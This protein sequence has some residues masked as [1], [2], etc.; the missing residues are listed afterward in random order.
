MY[1]IEKKYNTYYILY[2]IVISM[3]YFIYLMCKKYYFINLKY[4]IILTVQ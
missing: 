4:N 1:R 3:I 2:I